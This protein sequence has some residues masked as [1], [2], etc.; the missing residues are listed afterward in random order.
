DNSSLVA[1]L[2]PL[3]LML[4]KQ[5]F[6]GGKAPMF[7]DYVVFGAL[8]WLRTTA[9]KDVMPKDNRVAAWFE[10]LLNM[11]NGAGRTVPAAWQG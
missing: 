7:A 10:N 6:L 11:N 4:K 9:K 8:Q 3:E 5:P 1:A 2:L